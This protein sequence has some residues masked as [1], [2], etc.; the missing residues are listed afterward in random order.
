MVYNGPSKTRSGLEVDFIVYGPRGLWAIEVKNSTK[1][2]EVD[3]KSL[4]AFTEDY[5]MAKTILLYRGELRFREG[6]I[7]CIPCDDFLRHLRPN[8]PLS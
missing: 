3:L 8:Q 1:V 4:K 2:H 7:D 6:T 5:P